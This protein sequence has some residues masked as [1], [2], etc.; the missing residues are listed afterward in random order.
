MEQSDNPMMTSPTS[1]ITNV[2]TDAG[3]DRTWSHLLFSQTLTVLSSDPEKYLPNGPA[4]TV[5]TNAECPLNTYKACKSRVH[6]LTVS[7][8]E[9]VNIPISGMIDIYL[10][11]SSCAF[12]NLLINFP[13]AKSHRLSALS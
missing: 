5:N 8:F 4:L 11:I 12:C 3:M 6:A 9:H 7:S 2:Q 1:S 13:V 10:I